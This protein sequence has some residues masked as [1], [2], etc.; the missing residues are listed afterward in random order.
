[1]IDDVGERTKRL[2]LASDRVGEFLRATLG[3]TLLYAAQVAPEIAHSIDDVDRAMRWGFGWEIGP[4]ELWDAIG[5]PAVIEALGSSSVP[6]LVDQLRQAGRRSFRDGG[7]PPASPDF[8]ILTCA[9]DQE[10]VVRRNAGASLVDL[11]DGV[12]ALEFHSK[13]NTIG[14]DT[15]QMMQAALKIASADF[16]AIVI[17]ND[18]PH[19]SAGANLMLV[20]LE[21]QEGN[22]EELDLMVRSFQAATRALREADVPVVACPAGRVLG[23]GSRLSCIATGLR[24]PRK[25]TSVWWRPASG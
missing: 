23:G 2:F 24:Q 21:A 9:K 16:Q 14:G 15:I 3:R 10:R 5:V 25:P 8:S 7:L 17:G 20:L 6:P 13:A 1:A 4:F 18:A 11:G 19:F 12:L 22:W